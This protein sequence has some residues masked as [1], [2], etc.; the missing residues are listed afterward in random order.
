MSP[1]AR[2]PHPSWN[3]AILR[4]RPRRPDSA[5]SAYQRSLAITVQINDSAGQASTLNELGNLYS[6]IGRTEE[7]VRLYLQGAEI[8]FQLGDLRNE[9]LLRSNIADKFVKLGRFDE[10]RR[11]IDRAIE[12]DKPFGHVAAPW[13]T[14]AILS[15]LERAVG[16]QPA[17][18]EART[19][20]M[21]AYL[22]YRHAGGAPEIDPTQIIALVH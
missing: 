12:C 21:E 1:P 22:G 17:A 7:E 20:A 15:N 11:E 13:N 16:N 18:L 10:A 3:V 2:H 6:R 5:E 19:R 8:T 14:L 4:P 9:G